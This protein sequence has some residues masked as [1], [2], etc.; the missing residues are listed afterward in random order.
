MSIL[1]VADIE[2]AIR[3]RLFLSSKIEGLAWPQGLC[4]LAN[5]DHLGCPLWDC[6]SLTLRDSRRLVSG[7]AQ[8][9][10]LVDVV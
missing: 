2:V 6:F 5:F 10:T 1:T 8:Q 3:Q 9:F 4:K 7:L